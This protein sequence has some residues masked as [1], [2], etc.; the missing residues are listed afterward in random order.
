[1]NQSV[2]PKLSDLSI[3]LSHLLQA[4]VPL[5]GFL[6]FIMILVGGFQI[7]TAGSNPE[8]LEKGKKTLTYAIIGLALIVLSWL[9][10]KTIAYLTGAHILQFKITL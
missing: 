5:T 7:L 3:Y 4:L 8:N 9:I 6:A 2:A 1:M 10:L